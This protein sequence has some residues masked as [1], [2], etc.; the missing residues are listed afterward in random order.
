MRIECVQVATVDDERLRERALDS[1][2]VGVAVFVPIGHDREGIRARQRVVGRRRE[3]DVRRDVLEPCSGLVHRDRIMRRN[4]RSGRE[5]LSDER[6]RGRLPHIV[7]V[8]F[9]RQSP[10]GDP[11]AG[12]V[13]AE[14]LFQLVKQ[15]M[16]LVVVHRLDGGENPQRVGVVDADLRA[17]AFTSLGKQEPP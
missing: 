10:D 2:E 7:R 13:A 14:R 15:P 1:R 6:Q 11:A 4:G 5:Q 8:R 17:S 3:R 12:E 16:L 9:E